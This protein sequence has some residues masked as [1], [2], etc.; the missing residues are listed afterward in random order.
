MFETSI[1]APATPDLHR[2]IEIEYSPQGGY[3]AAPFLVRRSRLRFPTLE[4]A[5]KHVDHLLDTAAPRVTLTAERGSR[6]A[7]TAASARRAETK[8][9]TGIRP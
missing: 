6:Q 9:V 3:D 7:Y 5:R 2:G 4:K 8:R 1:H